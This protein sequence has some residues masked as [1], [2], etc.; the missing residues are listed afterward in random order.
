MAGTII[1]YFHTHPT[2]QPLL[3]VAN[4]LYCCRQRPREPRGRG[5]YQL[6]RGAQAARGGSRI[7]IFISPPP[8]PPLPLFTH[9][10][11]PL[12]HTPFFQSI[13]GRY[14]DNLSLDQVHDC[15]TD[16]FTR[17]AL[18][19]QASVKRAHVLHFIGHG[20]CP[21]QY[22]GELRGSLPLSLGPSGTHY[23]PQSLVD[24]L[25]KATSQAGFCRLVVLQACH[26]AA[27][28]LR[29]AKACPD[30]MVVCW[31]SKLRDDGVP[32]YTAALYGSLISGFCGRP[33][34]RSGK[35]VLTA[36]DVLHAFSN[37]RTLLTA[38]HGFS[39]P[40][41]E[42]SSAQQQQ[43]QSRARGLPEKPRLGIPVLIVGS[44]VNMKTVLNTKPWRRNPSPHQHHRAGTASDGGGSTVD[45]SGGESPFIVGAGGA[46]RSRTTHSGS[47][48][49]DSIVGG[50]DGGSSS[51]GGGSSSGLSGGISSG[52][53][54]GGR[55][56]DPPSLA[57]NS[58]K[59]Y[60]G[61]SYI[62][63]RGEGDG[64]LRGAVSTA[65]AGTKGGGGSDDDEDFEGGLDSGSSEDDSSIIQSFED[66]FNASGEGL[67]FWYK[68]SHEGI[69]GQRVGVS[70]FG[71]VF[72]LEERMSHF[73]FFS[74]LPSSTTTTTPQQVIMG[75][76][77]PGVPS[78]PA[79]I[80][81]LQRLEN[82]LTGSIHPPSPQQAAPPHTH[83]HPPSAPLHPSQYQYPSYYN[84]LGG[85]VGGG[86]FHSGI[87]PFVGGGGGVGGGGWPLCPHPVFPP[88]G[89]AP[90]VQ[91]Q[92]QQ[93]SSAVA[94]T[95][96]TRSPFA[97]QLYP[98]APPTSQPP[99]SSLEDLQVVEAEGRWSAHLSPRLSAV[100]A[101]AKVLSAR[102]GLGS[103]RV[104]GF[105]CDLNFEPTAAQARLADAVPPDWRTFYLRSLRGA[106]ARQ[107]VVALLKEA[108]AGGAG[109]F[110]PG[111]EGLLASAAAE[112]SHC[113]EQLLQK[114][115]NVEA[116]YRRAREDSAAAVV[117][118][119]GDP[120][121]V[122]GGG[123]ASSGGGGGGGF[124]PINMGLVPEAT[125]E[126]LQVLRVP[127]GDA[128]RAVV[129][130]IASTGL[131]DDQ[132]RCPQCNSANSI[133]M[134]FCESGCGHVFET[135]AGQ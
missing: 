31:N 127:K 33:A 134:P 48:L 113:I 110:A 75:V 81:E 96:T 28:G 21:I 120:G 128:E 42:N 107:S 13:A 73:H 129:A 11:P 94:S 26:T 25:H 118:E 72:R 39:E 93:Q 34:S 19:T 10:P 60:E 63:S 97:Q 119:D 124:A 41:Y 45:N 1:Y 77:L 135:V 61:R 103:E 84:P 20:Y 46:K 101:L 114:V 58:S 16:T 49:G 91:H 116:T 87:G 54:S 62:Y 85:G 29:L 5:H 123:G 50:G 102:L 6:L 23:D 7:F 9:P 30:A 24:A 4:P 71:F 115:G 79:S 18:G 80:A 65:S 70:F 66:M 108:I 12:P 98:P 56:A 111:D 78:S 112:Q 37:A 36:G 40:H 132:R 32:K 55:T 43:Q 130:V 35:R 117:V 105:P 95:T 38:T 99:P 122:G 64:S 51:Q 106:H 74:L 83:I 52:S 133:F 22:L 68:N 2:S 90:P 47:D 69:H 76:D 104:L 8:R 100:P 86:A 27:F 131:E 59:G 17:I 14:P 53:G 125:A 89:P 57:G 126:Q 92:L 44:N 15:D 109:E 88:Y 121:A 3:Y 67:A 82:L